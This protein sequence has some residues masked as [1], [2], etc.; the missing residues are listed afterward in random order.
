MPE[1]LF[2][3]YFVVE[4]WFTERFRDACINS[5][6][7]AQYIV[8]KGRGVRLWTSTTGNREGNIVLRLTKFCWHTLLPVYR[9]KYVCLCL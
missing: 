8:E 3:Y 9:S 4:D 7:T 5:L 2:L 1:I 6:G